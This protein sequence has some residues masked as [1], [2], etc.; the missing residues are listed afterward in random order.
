[1]KG[2]VPIVMSSYV[3]FPTANHTDKISTHTRHWQKHYTWFAKTCKL[4]L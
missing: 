3:L 1:M 4:F 2:F